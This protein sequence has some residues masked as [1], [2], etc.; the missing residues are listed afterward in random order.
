MSTQ[1]REGVARRVVAHLEREADVLFAY[2]FGSLAIGTFRPESDVDV[3]VSLRAPGDK[4]MRFERRLQLEGAL[5]D[6]T[7]RPVH[8]VDLEGAHP[9]LQHQVR[10][11]GRL[12]IDKDPARRVKLEV[13]A[14]RRYLDM[15]PVY[16]SRRQSALKLLKAPHG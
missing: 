13:A 7:G 8:V 16:R 14:R 11:T 10:K 9:L 4:V 6:A 1:E 3:A 2:I 15:L 5:Q 12:I